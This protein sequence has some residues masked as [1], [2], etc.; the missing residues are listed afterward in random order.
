MNNTVTGFRRKLTFLRVIHNLA[1]DILFNNDFL[2]L[3]IYSI[4]CHLYSCPGEWAPFRN[5]PNPPSVYVSSLFV[6]LIVKTSS[7][8]L[9]FFLPCWS[10]DDDF[11][12][13]LSLTCR[14]WRYSW[15]SISFLNSISLY[16]S[17]LVCLFFGRTRFNF[18]FRIPLIMFFYFPMYCFSFWNIWAYGE[19]KYNNGP[20]EKV[21]I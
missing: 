17:S 18:T 3:F 12:I 14:N 8:E 19:G 20:R 10:H 21:D 11:D 2:R 15:G 16:F 6:F 4:H 1:V 7:C 5:W 13:P 9:V